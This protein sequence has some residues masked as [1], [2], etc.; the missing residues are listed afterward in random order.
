MCR[1]HRNANREELGEQPNFNYQGLLFFPRALPST[2]PSPW[3]VGAGATRTSTNGKWAGHN[4]C[5]AALLDGTSQLRKSD[6]K[7]PNRGP[8]ETDESL[9][10]LGLIISTVSR[11]SQSKR[12]DVTGC[13]GSCPPSGVFTAMQ[14][15]TK[16]VPGCGAGNYPVSSVDFVGSQRCSILRQSQRL[17]IPNLMVHRSLRRCLCHCLARPTH[18]AT[19]A[20]HGSDG[21]KNQTSSAEDLQ[22]TDIFR[23]RTCMPPANKQSETWPDHLQHGS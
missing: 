4:W 3:P 16:P 12:V 14:N 10:N 21:P 23:P 13:G 1:L 20:I 19:L 7:G 8:L 2:Q 9:G 15:S 18:C 5:E 6:S 17:P 11:G 22:G